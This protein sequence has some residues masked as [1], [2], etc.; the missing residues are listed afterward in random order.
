MFCLCAENDAEQKEVS[1]G[2]GGLPWTFLSRT[3]LF[4]WEN[5]GK[6]MQKASPYSAFFTSM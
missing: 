5:S 4:P 2:I 6:E 3:M 1:M